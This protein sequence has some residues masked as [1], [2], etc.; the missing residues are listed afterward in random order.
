MLNFTC[1]RL[2][3]CGDSFSIINS[4]FVAL[5][6]SCHSRGIGKSQRMISYGAEDVDTVVLPL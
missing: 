5:V 3:V 2:G 6:K 4:L 1:S